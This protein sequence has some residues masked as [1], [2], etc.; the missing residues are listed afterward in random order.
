MQILYAAAA[1]G[2]VGLIF[3]TLL[4]LAARFFDVEADPRVEAVRETLPG[5]NCGACGYAGCTNFAEAVVEGNAAQNGCIP[6]GGD[7]AK[8][9]AAVLGQEA[10]EAVPLVATVFCIGDTARARDLFIYD[11]VMDCAVAQKYGGGFK[12]CSD[13]CLGLGNCVRACPFDAITMGPHGLPVV[14][15]ERCGG[16]GLCSKA[17]PRGIIKILPKGNQGHLVLCSSQGRGKAVT[18]ACEVG[19]M[20]CKACIKAC[21]REA[22]TMDGNLAVID[23]AKCDDCGECVWKCRPGTIHPRCQDPAARTGPAAKAAA[24]AEV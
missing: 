4:A 11:G 19:C 10:V 7:T 1:L 20:A 18:E 9:I 21:P 16:C 14:N 3:G 17:C 22:I 12:A 23:L 8:A 6:G 24:C 15:R 2:G 13:G 5:V